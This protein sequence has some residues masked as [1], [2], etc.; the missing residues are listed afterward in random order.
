M[1]KKAGYIKNTLYLV[2]AIFVLI[3]CSCAGSSHS[4]YS[5][6]SLKKAHKC[7]AK[8]NSSSSVYFY[9]RWTEL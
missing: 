4:A 8:T 6:S 7:S 3:A 1:F 5:D 2:I 9:K